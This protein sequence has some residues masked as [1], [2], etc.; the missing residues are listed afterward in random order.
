MK[1][2]EYLVGEDR[3]KAISDIRNKRRQGARKVPDVFGNMSH[4]GWLYEHR[5]RVR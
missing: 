2:G 4:L 5:L 3:G 1:V